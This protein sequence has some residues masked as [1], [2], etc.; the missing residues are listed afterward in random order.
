MTGLAGWVVAGILL[1]AGVPA[2]HS[3]SEG[4][5]GPVVLAASQ[6]EVHLRYPPRQQ[7]E[8]TGGT[9]IVQVSV[10]LSG[11]AAGVSIRLSSGD[12]S[13]DRAAIR[14]AGRLRFEPALRYGR[15]ADGTLLVP[16]NFTSLDATVADGA[17]TPPTL[18]ELRR[19]FECASSIGESE[20]A[21]CDEGGLR[22]AESEV[23]RVY[24][25]ALAHDIDADLRA[26][27]LDGHR[28]WLAD[29]N[30]RCRAGA[31][32]LVRDSRDRAR[33]VRALAGI[34]P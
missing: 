33:Y 9:A 28:T 15:P 25:L 16:V 7:R 4:L 12:L 5:K 8:G 22:V 23:G 34:A 18:P 24:G 32:C 21:L 20:R 14:Y 27:I 13:L 26:L 2:A 1:L 11:G 3:S 19:E 10:D 17:R 31:A 29:R 6:D 30:R